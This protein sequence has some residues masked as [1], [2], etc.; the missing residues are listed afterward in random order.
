MKSD[1]TYSPSKAKRNLSRELDDQISNEQIN[2]QDGLANQFRK[3]Q[4]TVAKN[5]ANVA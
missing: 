5:V 4:T 3:M 1:Y 2:N